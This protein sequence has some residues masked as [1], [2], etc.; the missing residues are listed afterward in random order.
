MAGFDVAIRYG[1][2]MGLSLAS[3][4][5]LASSRWSSPSWR[6]CFASSETMYETIAGYA[7]GGS[8]IAV[9]GRVGGGLSTKAANVGS[10][11]CGWTWLSRAAA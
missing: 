4:G 3:L 10:H 11:T 7:L 8:S 6:A 2:V 1:C 9:F 5:T